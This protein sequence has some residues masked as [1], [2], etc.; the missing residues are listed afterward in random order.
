V[1]TV[2]DIPS[3]PATPAVVETPAPSHGFAWSVRQPAAVLGTVGALLLR[4]WPVLLALIFVGF[5]ARRGL[6]VVAVQ[7]SKLDGVFGFLVFALVPV[8]V[9]TSLVLM[10][11]VLSRSLPV[12]TAGGE[13]GARFRA[14]AHVASVLLPFIAVYAS[15]GYFEADRNHYIY[16]VFRDEQFDNADVFTDPAAVNVD[17]RLPFELS[18]TLVVV[19]LTAVVLRFVLGLRADRLWSWVGFVRAYLE[20]LSITVVTVF[21]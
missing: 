20:V 1:L 19:A 4:H 18:T 6:V 15:Y 14:L 2:T 17:E 13:P 10:L 16:E 5:A 3:L 9:M 8:A 21:L 12:A 11:R 7:A